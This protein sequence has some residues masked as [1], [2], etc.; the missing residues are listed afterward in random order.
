MVSNPFESASYSTRE[1]DSIVI[2]SFVAWTRDLDFNDTGYS[3]RYDLIPLATGST[4]TIP[5]SYV[6]GLWVFEVTS[7]LTAAWTAGEYRMNLVVVRTSDSEEAQLET[8]HVTI[9]G[10][11][12]DRR[13]HAEIMV[14]K[15]QS[16]LEGRADHDVESYSIK[17]RSITRM[18]VKE[19]REWRDYY[20]DE[21]GRTG[22]S[23]S[24]NETAN[25]NTIRTRFI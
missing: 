1:P 22:G 3:V 16:V 6:D 5:A 11:T 9:F 15:I 13:T 12:D 23:T 25:T 19:L 14:Q 21:I 4:L 8:G 20:L 24:K 2:G 10:S 18:S 7:T 17:S